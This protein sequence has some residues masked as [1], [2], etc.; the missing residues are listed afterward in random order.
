M[1]LNILVVILVQLNVFVIILFYLWLRKGSEQDQVEIKR[2]DP[3][4]II[5]SR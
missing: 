5:M 2:R 4:K 3:E 1:Y